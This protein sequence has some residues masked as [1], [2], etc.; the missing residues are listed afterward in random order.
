MQQEDKAS[1]IGRRG[2]LAAGA[3]LLAA[4]GASEAPAQTS[5][6]P[7]VSRRDRRLGETIAEFVVAF[8]LDKAPA[9][10]IE[11]TR[12]AFIDTIGVM[13]GGAHE[14]VAEIAREMIAVEASASR[15][16]VAGSA[17]RTS[18]QLAELGNGVAA[19]A[20]DF[21]FSYAASQAVSPVIP[22]LLPLA[23]VTGATP[24]EAITAFIVAAEV[25]ARLVR[26]NP[27]VSALG[28]WHPVG[29]VGAIATAAA[30]ARLMKAP[31]SVIPDIIGIAASLSS[32]F[33]ANFG[34]MTKPLHSG[35]AA[36]NG[37]MAAFLG[38]KG[39]TASNTALEARAGYFDTFGRGLPLIAD[40]FDD[41][42]RK[43]ELIDRGYKI[44]R[45]PCGGLSH[46]SIDATLALREKLAG[47]IGEIARIEAG[48]TSNAFSKIGAVY[49]DT[50][51]NAK[52][53]MP[54]IGAWTVLYGPPSLK[55]FTMAAI[56]DER[57][58]ALSAKISHRADPEFADEII[59]APGRVRV[60][61]TNGES[62]EE[63]VWF[64]SG[65]P[66]NPMSPAQIEAKFFDC[67]RLVFREEQV[68]RVFAF[69]S[70]LPKQVSFDALW[71]M[72]RNG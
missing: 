27:K 45:Y 65:S 8:D 71:P 1:A 17:L 57:V 15:A 21:D 19:H 30:C 54:Y 48:V 23:E 72:L 29:M 68:R 2:F 13:L 5:V 63:K 61:L 20:M 42:G 9:G 51:E 50:I 33:N 39:F 3:G 47:R 11:R 14:E 12:V 10:L 32:G 66:Q 55:T 18:P 59:E 56:A 53:S 70:D 35:N 46:T 69:A 43:F 64:P 16:T 25:A 6:A 24:R 52:F 44:K 31:A 67:A 22:A 34:T 49:P 62:L 4:T 36:R 41:L 26:A 7:R 40:A 38:A 58:K 60:T 28:G 37:M